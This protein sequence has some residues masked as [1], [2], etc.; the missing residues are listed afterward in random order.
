VAR[1]RGDRMTTFIKAIK[2][3]I[4]FVF[5]NGCFNE[6]L[7]NLSLLPPKVI[8]TYSEGLF[9]QVP[10]HC[11]ISSIIH[12]VFVNTE[13]NKSISYPR[14]I[15]I[16]GE[17]SRITLI[18]DY[19]EQQSEYYTT[20]AITEIHANKNSEVSYYKLQNEHR[21]ATHTASLIVEQKQDSQVNTFFADYGSGSAHENVAVRLS[22]RGAHCQMNGIYYL[23]QDAQS[24]HTAI[25]VNHIAAFCT[26]SM[27]Y[28]GVLDKKSQAVFNGKIHVKQEAQKTVAHQANHNLLLAAESDIQTKPELEIYADDVKCT[29]GA[30]VGQLNEAMIFYLRTRGIEKTEA[31]KLL[32]QAFVSDAMEKINNISVKEYIRD[33]FE[34][35]VS[36]YATP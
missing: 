10:S 13:K 5:V 29:H 7:S 4:S 17:S 18:E 26:S 6:T 3:S 23:N 15:I 8:F 30:T 32:T 21:T 25:Q 12:L 34:K 22:E 20:Q 14:N 28:K 27:I 19:L 31:L 16:V 11:S 1:E 2:D 36:Q 9:L 35:R 24:V 33:S